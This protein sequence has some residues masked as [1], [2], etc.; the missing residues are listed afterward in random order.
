MEK[1]WIQ[2]PEKLKKSNN[3]DKIYDF[4]KAAAQ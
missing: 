2:K 3:D 4:R 1:R